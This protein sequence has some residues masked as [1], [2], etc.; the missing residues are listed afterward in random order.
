MLPTIDEL[1]E[2]ARAILDPV[3]YDYFV[4]GA[5]KEITAQDNESAYRRLALRP[6]VLR[7]SSQRTIAVNLFGDHCDLPVVVSPTAFHKLAHPEGELATARG[8]A[9]A[10][11]ILIASMAATVAVEDIAAEARRINSGARIWFQLYIQ[12]DF[13]VTTALVRR[14]E[15]AGVSALVVTADSPELGRRERD[16]R[17][18]FHDLPPGLY[19]ANMRDL[20]H[21]DGGDIRQIQMSPDIS[22]EHVRQ[23]RDI[24]DLPIVIKGVLHPEDA[25]LAVEQGI[26][27]LLVSNHGGRQLDTVPAT[28]DAL[29]AIAHVV[30]GRVPLLIDGGIRSGTDIAMALALGATAVGVGRPI[31][32]GLTV[33][34]DKGV[35]EVLARLRAE[36]DHTVAMCGCRSLADLTPDLV[37]ARRTAFS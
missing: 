10:N 6:R 4:G 37:V 5:G 28:I 18:D 16:D 31:L 1:R 36:F 24:T 33:G 27:G 13:D 30:D 29:P 26:D 7:G 19:A 2:Q 17:N 8:T 32:W 22:W 9:M 11:T 35:V 12:P 20:V 14:A 23:L 21:A 34:G 15:R 3:H 25:Q